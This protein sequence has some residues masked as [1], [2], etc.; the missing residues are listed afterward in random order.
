MAGTTSSISADFRLVPRFLGEAGE[1]VF[2]LQFCPTVAPKAH[3]VFLP[4]FAEEMN[5][6]RSVVAAQARCFASLGYACT[7]LD[8]YGT[9]DSE[10]VLRDCTL[11]LWYDNIETT[12][13]TLASDFSGPVHLWGLRLGGLLALDFSVRR[14]CTVDGLLLWQPVSGAKL[15]INQMLRQRVASLMVK[16]QNAE[17]TKEIRQRLAAGEEVEIAGYTLS[18]A[19]VDDI[20]SID[21]ST[22]SVPCTGDMHWFE[23]TSSPEAEIGVP[24]RNA[25]ELLRGHGNLVTLHTYSDP[26]VWQIANRESAPQLVEKTSEVYR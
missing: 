21:L 26:P 1:R 13:K 14:K 16:G 22:M 7:L 6:C 25:I 5:R 12:L 15:Y 17:T 2:T 20:E 23:N 24:A 3:I 19:L 18:G 11:D 9:G 4:A 10:G 8:F